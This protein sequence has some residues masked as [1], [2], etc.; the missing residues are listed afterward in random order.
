M[1]QYCTYQFFFKKN[2]LHQ[3]NETSTLSVPQLDDVLA[4]FGSNI[5]NINLASFFEIDAVQRRCSQHARTLT[6]MNTRTQT[7]P[8]LVPPKD[9]A[10]TDLEILEVTT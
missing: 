6:P 4:R 5:T 3:Q 1:I 7:L 10:P 8:L 9:W 2:I